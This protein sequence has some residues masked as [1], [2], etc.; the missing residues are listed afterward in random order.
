[1]DLELSKD[2]WLK[3]TDACVLLRCLKLSAPETSKNRNLLRAFAANCGKHDTHSVD[4]DFIKKIE[5]VAR[6]ELSEQ[7]LNPMREQ[8]LTELD[9][10]YHIDYD[11]DPSYSGVVEA[12]LRPLERMCDIDIS[13]EEL[14][15]VAMEMV[16]RVLRRNSIYPDRASINEAGLANLLRLWLPCPWD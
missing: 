12:D 16:T 11:K 3:A 5:M 4:P 1:M 6:Q 15:D 14:C 2:A 10:Y 7:V 9:R 8:V 13:W